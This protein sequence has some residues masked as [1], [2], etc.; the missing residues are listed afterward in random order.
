MKN[1]EQVYALLQEQPETRIN[2]GTTFSGRPDMVWDG[3]PEGDFTKLLADSLQESIQKALENAK[4]SEQPSR[5]KSAVY[6]RAKDWFISN[7]PLLGALAASFRIVDN[8]DTV[9]RM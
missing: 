9:R 3:K 5:E 8:M 2:F 7:Y 6:T 1:E 4:Y